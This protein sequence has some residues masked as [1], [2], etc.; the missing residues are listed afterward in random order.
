MGM[1]LE[2]IAHVL[3]REEGRDRPYSRM[4][5]HNIEASAILNFRRAIAAKGVTPEEVR[6][7][8]QISGNRETSWDKI[9]RS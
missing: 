5:I 8:L 4:T 1:S 3:A 9:E 7:F 2:E 6:D